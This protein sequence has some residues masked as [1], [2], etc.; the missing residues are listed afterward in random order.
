MGILLT[1]RLADETHAAAHGRDGT[2]VLDPLDR[3]VPTDRVVVTTERAICR[4]VLV[5]AETGARFQRDAVPYDAMAWMLSPRKVFDG[6]APIEAC[7][8][9][10]A[11]L[12][13]VLV[14]GLSLGL[15]VDKPEIDALMTAEDDDGFDEAEFEYLYGPPVSDTPGRLSRSRSGRTMRLRLYT[16]TLADTRNNVMIQAFHASMARNVGE[17]RARLVGRFGQDLADVADIRPGIHRA[18][19]IVMALVPDAVIE[20]IRRMQ[21]D[22]ASPAARTFGV[23]IQQCIQA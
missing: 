16:A 1:E 14:H 11:C 2:V 15:D 3:D 17:V 21:R 6:M 7:L 12:R 4:V 23:D 18:S 13:G 20:V 5:A 9:R 19:P 10:D 8:Q 22:H